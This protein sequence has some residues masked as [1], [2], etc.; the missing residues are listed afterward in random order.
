MILEEKSMPFAETIGDVETVKFL[1]HDC[2]SLENAALKLLITRSVGPRIL[3]LR[4]AGGENILAELPD[5]V[6]DCPGTG[7][8]HFRGGHRLWHA[9]E[10][11]GR[12]YLPDDAPV[13]ISAIEGGLCATQ[14]VEVKTSLQKSMDIRLQGEQPRAVILHRL[15]NC[16]MWPVEC[17]PWA[18]TQLMNGGLAI[19]P[20]AAEQSGVL[21]NRSVALWP[22]TNPGD[23]HVAWGPHYILIQGSLD[24]PFKIGFPNPR[25]WLA[26]WRNGTLFVKR[27]RYAPQS[28]YYDFGSSSEFYGNDQFIELETLAPIHTIRPGA[29][30]T[31][32]ETWELYGQVDRPRD[33]KDVQA[34]VSRLHLES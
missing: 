33:E 15:T 1:G 28:A 4:Y 19:L 21:P 16:G 23:P 7:V 6:A 2:V 18:I 8:F 22:Y 12:T 31:H 3:A 26:Y 14:D 27:A 25:G 11:L 24:A 30:A 17:S 29:S 32:T 9:P 13:A 5:F 20:Q 34:L 10:D